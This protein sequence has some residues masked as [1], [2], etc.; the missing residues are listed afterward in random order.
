MIDGGLPDATAGFYQPVR[1]VATAGDAT[2]PAAYRVRYSL[3]LT[4]PNQNPAIAGVFIVPAGAPDPVPVDQLVPLDE[5]ASPEVHV[6]DKLNLRA[7][8]VDG[9]AETYLVPDGDPAAGKTRQVT[10]VVSIAWYSTA[11]DLGTGV[12]G[13]DQPDTELTFK[14]YTPTPAP[15][16]TPVDLWIVARDER[17]G[18]DWV[19]RGLLLK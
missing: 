17:G 1:L 15:E 2:V 18:T 19:H 4:P 10:E 7:T 12:T 14:K 16:G 6:G 5:A 8:L 3:G 9:S 13:V 11:G